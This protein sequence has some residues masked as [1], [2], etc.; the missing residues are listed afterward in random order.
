MGVS[1]KKKSWSVPLINT[2]F[3]LLLMNGDNLAFDILYTEL[4]SV[5]T[6]VFLKLLT[7]SLL[8]YEIPVNRFHLRPLCS[9]QPH[10]EIASQH[11]LSGTQQQHQS[12]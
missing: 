11:A 3:V 4:L 7:Q 8:I 2:H 6:S 1:D 5:E 12:L 10:V 9:K